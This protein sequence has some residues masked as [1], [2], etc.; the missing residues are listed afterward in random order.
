MEIL[1]FPDLSRKAR[2][3]TDLSL[4]DLDRML[5]ST[6]GDEQLSRGERQAL[7]QVLADVSPDPQRLALYRH[8]AFGL[9]KE[10][11]G[12][13]SDILDWLEEVV[14]VFSP[15][16]P[17]SP[18]ESHAYFTPGDDCAGR[19]IDLIRQARRSIDICVF[20]IT[21][22]QIASAIEQAHHRSIAIRIITDHG[23]SLDVGSDIERM[24]R[25]GVNIRLETTDHH[26]HHKFAI[27][28]GTTL[29]N[30]SY[31]WTRSAAIYNQENILITNDP[32]LVKDFSR[33]FTKL[34]NQFR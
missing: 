15:I 7:T 25:E 34:W 32:S 3:S 9:A 6:L 10:N 13:R 27:F 33:E 22:D 29:V 31:N 23:K 11:M 1:H 19:I 14:K 2:M 18:I 21:H 5:L 12:R 28:D 17:A 8:R 26:M 4:A 30:G 16:A 20:T 24:A